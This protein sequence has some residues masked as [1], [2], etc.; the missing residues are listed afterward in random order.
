MHQKL[1]LEQSYY[2]KDN[3]VVYAYKSFDRHRMKIF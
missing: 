1:D 2:K 3:L